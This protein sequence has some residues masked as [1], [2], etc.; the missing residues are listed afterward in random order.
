MFR[1]LNVFNAGVVFLISALFMGCGDGKTPVVPVS[2]QV[3]VGGKPAEG[4]LVRL[5]PVDNANPTTPKPMGYV[6]AEGKFQLTTY[7]ADDGAPVGKYRATIEWRPK[8]KSTMEADG[9]DQ[10]KGKYADP[11]TSKFEVVV[12]KDKSTLDLIKID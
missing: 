3:I 12:S 6:N 7:T 11:N 9:P 2:G 8:K 10:L 5:H 4:A 1:L